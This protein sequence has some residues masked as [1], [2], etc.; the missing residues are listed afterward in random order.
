M[1]HLNYDIY[2]FQRTN[3][4]GGGGWKRSLKPSKDMVAHEILRQNPRARLNQKNI[5]LDEFLLRIQPLT[6][7]R[8]VEFVMK[9]EKN[10]RKRFYELLD[11]DYTQD[12]MINQFV[13]AKPR[14]VVQTREIQTI[15]SKQK[16][17]NEDV[18]NNSQDI[19]A[20][21]KT[22]PNKKRQKT[23]PTKNQEPAVTSSWFFPP[24]FTLSVA[25]AERGVNA[26]IKF[27]EMRGNEWDVSIVVVDTTGIPLIAKRMDGACPASYDI[28][29]SR[30][31]NAA[32]FDKSTGEIGKEPESLGQEQQVSIITSFS[33]KSGGWPIFVGD[34]KKCIG[35]MGVSGAPTAL[36]DEQVA[37]HGVSFINNLFSPGLVYGLN[38][39]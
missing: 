3:S 33:W 21:Y 14:A 5:K 1:L 39:K 23:T 29:H 38:K 13:V 22:T 17:E 37:K 15:L 2:V 20:Q 4:L 9:E 12:T 6:D 16:I 35:A 30:A 11:A 10:I 31:K 19:V 34:S 24:S 18:D 7:P 26:A 25:A 32:R 28:A 36:N 8:D 27:A